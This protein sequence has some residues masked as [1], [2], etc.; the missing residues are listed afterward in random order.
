MLYKKK[1]VFTRVKNEWDYRIGQAK[2]ADPNEPA[3]LLVK[4]SA[5]EPEAPY[6]ILDTDY[7]NYSL[8][9]SCA[10]F[11]AQKFEIVWILSREKTLNEKVV[12]VL[13]NTLESYNI[14]VSKFIIINQTNCPSNSR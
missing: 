10:T 8:V 9:F 7:D 4:F 13:K 3:K 11:L 2:I 1:A 6:W 5:N 14:D 12:D